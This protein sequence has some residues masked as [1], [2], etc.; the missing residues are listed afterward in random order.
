MATSGNS[1]AVLLLT[2][3][4]SR[5]SP[6]TL[7][8]RSHQTALTYTGTLFSHSKNNLRTSLSKKQS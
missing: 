5:N 8:R 1:D 7:A 3:H 4:L 2:A 6:R